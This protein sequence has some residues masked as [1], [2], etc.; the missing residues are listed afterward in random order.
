MQI[1][2]IKMNFK[3]KKPK[4]LEE[5]AQPSLCIFPQPER[6]RN[7]VENFSGALVLWRAG[8]TESGLGCGN[9]SPP[10]ADQL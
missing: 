3:E 4:F 6:D 8:F 9:A 5:L 7:E 10:N 2:A 1:A